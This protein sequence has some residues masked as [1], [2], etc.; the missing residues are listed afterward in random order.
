MKQLFETVRLAAQEGFSCSFDVWQHSTDREPHVSSLSVHYH[1]K[2]IA[3]QHRKMS[4]KEA[5][6]LIARLTDFAS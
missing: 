3:F 1:G 2:M 5:A 4:A 6:R